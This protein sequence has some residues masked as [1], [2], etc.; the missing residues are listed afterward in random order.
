MVD[1]AKPPTS[2]WAVFRRVLREQRAYKRH[3][4]G[5]M[6]LGVLSSP[7]ALVSPL[8]MKIV[9]DNYP[10]STWSALAREALEK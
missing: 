6:L 7:L 5:I 3:F 9:V 10:G 4:A 8:A 2:G 1:T